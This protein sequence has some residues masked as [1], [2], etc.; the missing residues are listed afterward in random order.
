MKTKLVQKLIGERGFSFGD[1]FV[2]GHNI[3]SQTRISQM[4]LGYSPNGLK[5]FR[6]FTP[7]QLFHIFL[8]LR[9]VHP[10]KFSVAITNL[11]DFLEIK[12]YMSK[13]FDQLQEIQRR[14]VFIAL[15]MLIFHGTIILD[16]PT[17][18]MPPRTCMEIWNIIRFYRFC[19]KSILFTTSE[20]RECE[21]IADYI[22]IYEG[23][24]MLAQGPPE[25]LIARYTVGFYLEIRI[26]R[27]GTDIKEV[28]EK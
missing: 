21:K 28:E 17:L 18:G 2:H 9:G 1:V 26:L 12:Q 13:R 23:G 11:S 14:K 24:E 25:E 27:D 19:G 8:M 3:K 6:I 22:I 20:S 15:G 5:G 10:S 16:E 4:T 7:K